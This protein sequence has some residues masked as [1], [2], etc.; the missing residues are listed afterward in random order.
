MKRYPVVLL[1]CLFLT[2]TSLANLVY[3]SG[4][5]TQGTSS[6]TAQYWEDDVSGGMW[7][8]SERSSWNN[9]DGDGYSDVIKG[10]WSGYDYAGSWQ[11]IDTIVTGQQYLVSAYFYYDNSWSAATWQIKVEWYDSN[12]LVNTDTLN[13]SGISQSTWT[14][15]STVVTAPSGV[16][17]A[18]FV[19]DVSGIVASGAMYM[20]QVV[21]E[22]YYSGYGLKNDSFENQGS[23]ED[24]ADQWESVTGGSWGSAERTTWQAYQGGYSMGV[25]GSWCGYDYGGCWQAVNV[26]AGVDYVTSAYFYYDNDWSAQN[27]RLT[28]EWYDSS[29]SRL[30]ATTNLL[31]NLVQNTWVKKT[32]AVTAPSNA[33]KAHFVLDVSNIGTNGVLYMDKAYF[34]VGESVEAT[35]TVDAAQNNKK[36]NDY[37]FGINIA[38]WCQ[39]YYLNLIAEKLKDLGVTLVR[40]GAT[41][42]E[43]YNYDNNRMYNV[44]SREN[45]Y[46][47]MS[48]ES[49][50]DW[51]I[52]DLEAD[53]FVQV[54]VYGHV[55]GEG[56]AMG[57]DGYDHPQSLAEVSNWVGGAGQYVKVWG[58]GN[59]PVIAWK[60]SDY[61]EFY[62]DG[63]HGDQVLNA[64]TRYSY[65][66]DQRFI[67]VANTIKSANTNAIVIGPTPAN[68]WL[69][70]GNDYSPQCPVTNALGDA[71]TNDAGW[72]SMESETNQWNHAVFPDRGDDPA[73][74]GW[75]T[76]TNRLLCQFAIRA[77]NA[78][79]TYNRRLV[80]YMDVH[81]YMNC[82]SDRDAI[83]E[84]RGLWQDGYQSWDQETG[85]SGTET[86][87]LKRFQN[88][89]DTHYPDTGLSFSEYD[90]FYWN[91]HPFESQI[92]A[93]IE[94][95]YLGIFARMGVKLAC[96]WYVGEPDQ[97]GGG[98]EHASDSAKQAMFNETG[99]PNPKYW[100]FYLMRHY[101]T[102][103]S[104][105]ADSTDWGQFT[106]HAAK[107]TNANE[108]V[109]VVCYKGEFDSTGAVVQAQANKSATIA[110]TNFTASSVK[111]ILR[112]GKNDPYVIEK[113][114]SGFTLQNNAFTYSFD[115]LSVYVFVL[116]GSGAT[117]APTNYLHVNPRALDFGP[118]DTGI[119]VSGT[120]T[121][122]HKGIKISNARNG[123]TTWS[124][125][126]S[127]SWLS[128]AGPSSGSAKVTDVAYLTA[129]RSGLDYGVYGTTVTVTTAEGTVEVPVTL[130]VVPGETNGEKRIC[131]FDTGSLAHTWNVKEPYSVGWWDGH[132]NPEDRDSPYIY[133]FS[134]ES[135]EKSRLGGLYSMKVEFDRANGDTDNGV[136]YLPFGTYGH[137]TEVEEEDG[138]VTT[139]TACA[140]WSGYDSLQFDLKTKTDGTG[141][142]QT[143]FLIVLTDEDGNKGKPAFEGMTDYRELMAVED[144]GWQTIT[145]PLTNTFYNWS[146]PNGQDG[147]TVSL[148]FSRIQQIEFA[149]W[150]SYE[151]K[152]GVMYIDNIRLVK[153]N[154]SGNRYPVAVASQAE[155]LIGTG[156]QVQ[157]TGSGSYDTDG[158]V[159]SYQWTPSA[160]LSNP[161]TANPTFSSTNA[162]T[163]VFD[164]IVT[165]NQ[166]LKSRNPAQ[167]VIKVMPT[168]VGSSIQ[169]YTDAAMSNEV[170]GAVTNSLDL[171]VK[172][173]CS[174][175][176]ND[177]QADFTMATV[178]S[179]D[180]YTGDTNN[181]VGSIDLL[182]E[183]TGPSTRLFTGHLRLAAFSD[184]DREM[185]GV[186]E[187]QSVTVSE[188]G[189]NASIAMGPQTFGFFNW[190]DRLETDLY[191]PDNFEGF[192][193]SYDDQPNGNQTEA[194]V[195]YQTSGA[196]TNSSKSIK[197]DITLHL[198]ATGDVDQLFG[199][200]AA[201][202]SPLGD[203]ITNSWA[204]LR[205]SMTWLK[206]LSFWMKGN[207]TKVSV[208]LKSANV[209]DY[210]DYCYTI[211]H[212]PNQWRRYFIPVKDF[213]H[214]E[215]WGAGV[216]M[217]EALSEIQSVQFKAASKVNGQWSEIYVDDLGL[218]GGYNWY[219]GPYCQGSSY[220]NNSFESVSD[221]TKW[222]ATGCSFQDAA[223]ADHAEGSY[224]IKL[225]STNRAYFIGMY[226]PGT[227]T[228]QGKPSI[229]YLSGVDGLA[230]KLKRP[231]GWTTSGDS[232]T[233]V[234]MLVSNSTTDYDFSDPGITR[235][236]TVDGSDWGDYIV[237]PKSKFY[238]QATV[239]SAC[240]TNGPIPW[241]TWGGN[242]SNVC[243]FRLEFGAGSE[244]GDP[245]DVLLDD[246]MTYKDA[247]D[248]YSCPW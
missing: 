155:K 180:G 183:E 179:S 152:S 24:K 186:S 188:A 209:N 181:N 76:D 215:G 43:R 50:V 47:P 58:V 248:E 82:W 214:Q 122:Y 79:T 198:S 231:S 106:V 133:R 156:D 128:V 232:P 150:M 165:D 99:E 147:T 129:S 91:G 176:G 65:L 100:A 137:I 46:V 168:L 134:L 2:H 115:P 199:G 102:D 242:W 224:A 148:D 191:Q 182:L 222:N 118:Y 109:V 161:D 103:T 229:T 9:S 221:F 201:K 169:F 238:T 90:L 73:V 94:T 38:N 190:I 139:N 157:L 37:I 233:R 127:A 153:E 200:I 141:F 144:G 96:N 89:V 62:A 107:Q 83:N 19:L 121:N 226:L 123:T 18:H 192:W 244:T 26:T 28:I 135:A 154:A 56:D 189:I 1:F 241:V 57:D 159:A 243:K 95:D 126:E 164:L 108:A 59:E 5:A 6:E 146:Y 12:T 41:N 205:P 104:V 40:F 217:E 202:L 236:R 15:Q 7:G 54:S 228:N 55:A 185:I 52:D 158:S 175:G 42:I 113:E 8:G 166:G 230:I 219:V 88:I 203:D 98:F 125:S 174:S 213:F 193:C 4:F 239:D 17:H 138:S 178:T 21:I 120:E 171:Y 27:T 63:A 145:I 227:G 44:I 97:S 25:Q 16:D 116:S 3:N 84:P 210:D 35:L 49:F 195:N 245:Y 119:T 60:R 68:W 93:L 75:E 212:T 20:D 143:R 92:P 223:D 196:H 77:N 208:I 80:D 45:Q 81:R 70:W 132:G 218:F 240:P 216:T 29:Y 124:I 23:T 30:N 149:P 67:P 110:I 172:L 101:F 160:G 136:L 34:G 11:S 78:E 51:C 64:Y 69:Y 86:K 167:V 32:F 130:E 33:A 220:T 22:P 163:Y 13:I 48:W 71:M 114:L 112:F 225:S 117:A 131:D 140:D 194:Y 197:G 177:N 206:G 235:W 66:F 207:G 74:T 87:L 184:E 14:Y 170:S 204:D 211:D 237:F 234:R 162:G 246:I 39:W 105:Q 111:K 36:I 85:C 173:T 142:T 72:A 151:D 53:P 31:S 187:G 61:P 247:A 10:S